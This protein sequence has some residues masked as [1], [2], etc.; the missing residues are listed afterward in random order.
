[1][2]LSRLQ[3]SKQRGN[4]LQNHRPTIRRQCRVSVLRSLTRSRTSGSL[5][6][7]RVH[8]HVTSPQD[9]AI[10]RGSLGC[11]SAFRQHAHGAFW[12]RC[13][14][15]H[16]C[17]FRGS[18]ASWSRGEVHLVVS[19]IYRGSEGFQVG[20]AQQQPRVPR[21]HVCHKANHLIS[22]IP[23]QFRCLL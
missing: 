10:D 15:I 3:F 18:V 9:P 14:R 12:Y 22:Q 23:F 6:P 13:R 4:Q 1:M 17:H 7:C 5:N 20:T 8:W 16:K 2:L 19:Q 11:I 21:N